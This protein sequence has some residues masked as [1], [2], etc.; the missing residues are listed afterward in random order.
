MLHGQGLQHKRGGPAGGGGGGQRRGFVVPEDFMSGPVGRRCASCQL[1]EQNCSCQG[2]EDAAQQPQVLPQEVQPEV[3]AVPVFTES[4]PVPVV[5]STPILHS[6]RVRAQKKK[7]RRVPVAASTRRVPVVASTPILARPPPV[8]QLETVSGTALPPP[9]AQMF[10]ESAS[11]YSQRWIIVDNSGSMSTRDGNKLDSLGRSV[12]CTRW[13]ELR[14]TLLFHG[15]LAER[16]NAP[17]HFRFLNPPRRGAAQYITVGDPAADRSGLANLKKSLRTSPHSTT[18]LCE[19]LRA[20]AHSLQ[21]LRRTQKRGAVMI[22]T[23]GQSSDGDLAVAL[24]PF[25]RLPCAV[26]V[27]LC[28]DV[29]FFSVMDRTSTDI[30]C[31]SCSQFDS[32]PHSL[33][34]TYLNFTL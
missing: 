3:V 24:E 29:S 6:S 13:E 33:M 28:T 16:L 17:T 27:R 8:D 30:L 31:E 32:P 10:H 7:S 9:I 4:L 1:M 11:L 12:P 15:E 20:V 25:A 22:A 21:E 14:Q 5:T 18:P 34:S 23:D 19:H 2:Y 26:V